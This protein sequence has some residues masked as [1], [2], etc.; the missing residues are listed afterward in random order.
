MV[1]VRRRTNE[2]RVISHVIQT[3]V[4]AS[5]TEVSLRH[6]TRGTVRTMIGC[7]AQ[8]LRMEMWISMKSR[9]RRVWME[10]TRQ[11]RR[12]DEPIN[13]QRPSSDR[14]ACIE[15]VDVAVPQNSRIL[16]AW[17]IDFFSEKKVN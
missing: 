10:K 1:V 2:F 12:K 9:S 6:A 4:V 16:A 11:R 5:R 3:R 13:Q 7:R 14:I 17:T 15:Q 8:E